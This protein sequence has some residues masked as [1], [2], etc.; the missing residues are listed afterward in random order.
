MIKNMPSNVITKESGFSL[1]EL[2][3]ATC[4]LSI[5]GSIVVSGFER[6]NH[7]ARLSNTAQVMINFI[8]SGR[9]MSLSNSTTCILL[10]N[11]IQKTVSINNSQECTDLDGISLGNIFQREE[12]M[13]VCGSANVSDQEFN[14]DVNL[15]P[16]TTIVFTPKGNASQ[17]A[18]IKLGSPRTQNGYCIVITEP[19]GHVM[20][21]RLRDDTCDFSN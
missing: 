9:R 12:D 6:Q 11:H 2:I 21:G 5:L 16:S 18:I 14:C 3:I 17:G 19:V 7:N 1:V 13:Q 8:E 4:I 15:A 10:V 20:K